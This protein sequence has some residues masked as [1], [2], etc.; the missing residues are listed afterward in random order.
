MTD[1]D[2][3]RIAAAAA[4]EALQE[5]LLLLGVDI[6]TPAGV[7]E[8]QRDFHHIRN[9]REAVDTVR[10]AVRSKVVDVLTGSAVTGA[11]GVVAYYV[12]HH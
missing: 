12:S 6:S 2:T 3:K 4:K 7:I 9:A 5:F 1:S 11:I 8:L 10:S